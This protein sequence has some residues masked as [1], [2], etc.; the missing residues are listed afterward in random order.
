MNKGRNGFTLIEVMITVAIVAILMSVAVPAYTNYITRG[1]LSEVFTGLGGVQTAAEQHWANRRTYA[2]MDALASFPK[3]SDNF[4]YA[5]TVGTA[6]A[7]TVTATGR[8]K[9]NG[10]VYTVDQNGTH[11]TTAT[12]SWGTNA[13]CWVDKKGGQCSN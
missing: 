1:R 5:L 10:F 12:P 6:S 4:T 13:S 8:N 3:D 9:M 11:A 2:G 7:Y